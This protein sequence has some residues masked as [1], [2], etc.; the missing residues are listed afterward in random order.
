MDNSPHRPRARRAGP[1]FVLALAAAFGLYSG[2]AAAVPSFARQ[3][4]QDCVACHVGGYGPQ[5][6]PYG[7]RFKLGGYTDS[8]GKDDKVPLSAMLLGGF[9]RTGKDQ[10]E[11][12]TDRTGR[13]NNLLLDQ[14]SLFVAGRAGE[15]LALYRSSAVGDEERLSLMEMLLQCAEEAD[16]DG[17]VALWRDIGPLLMARAELHRT[18]IDYWVDATLGISPLMQAVVKR[19]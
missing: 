6:T 9:T 13:N 4:G 3:T 16:P 14:A 12:P 15:Y 10:P 2:T 18:T 1:G 17:R 5:L 8:D 11:A 19:V 7:I